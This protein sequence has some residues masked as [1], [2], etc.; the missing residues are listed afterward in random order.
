MHQIKINIVGVERLQ[1]G[2]DA[3]FDTLVPWV[4]QFGGDPDLTARDTGIFDS[5]S[6]LCFVAVSKSTEG[7]VG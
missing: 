5:L 2:S 6:D 3:L 7:C 4:V 1:R